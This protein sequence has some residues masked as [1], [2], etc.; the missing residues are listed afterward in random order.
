MNPKIFSVDRLKDVESDDFEVKER[1]E[2][3][4]EM[5]KL[6]IKQKMMDQLWKIFL[7]SL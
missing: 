6:R 7:N 2:N 5:I 4:I 1:I 3:N